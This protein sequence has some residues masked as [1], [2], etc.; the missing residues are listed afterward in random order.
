MLKLTHFW[1][2]LQVKLVCYCRCLIR[3][4]QHKLIKKVL[5][6][7]NNVSLQEDSS[8]EK[9]LTF[10]HVTVETTSSSSWFMEVKNDLVEIQF[11]RYSN[12]FRE[13]ST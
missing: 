2:F 6:L 3:L 13:P 10:R 5:S 8:V 7:F 9:K 4:H 11:G 1:D 12:L